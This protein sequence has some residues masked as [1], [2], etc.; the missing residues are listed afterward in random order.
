MDI[1]SM[2]LL[3]VILKI[4]WNC[5]WL[6]LFI[7]YLVSFQNGSLTWCEWVYSWQ[8]DYINTS[9]PNFVGG[10]K[11]VDIALQQQRSAKVPMSDLTKANVYC[12]DKGNPS[13]LG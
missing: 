6:L 5:S 13:S 9:H 4:I 1:R 2:K 11:A 7:V 12:L 10:S 8:M 3:M